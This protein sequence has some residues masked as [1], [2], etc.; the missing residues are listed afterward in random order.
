MPFTAAQITTGATYT[1]NT[2]QRTEPLDQVNNKHVLL[3]WLLKN[4]QPVTFGNGSHRVPLY[5]ANT[6]NY[7]NYFG[8]DQ[9]TYNER[10]PA[11]WAEYNHYNFHDGFWFDEDRLAAN[12]IIITDDANAVPTMTEK[13]Q[14]ID[15]LKISYR[16]LKEGVQDQLS[17]ELYRDGTQSNKACPGA[18]LLV[19][20]NPDTGTVAGI[21]QA[22]STW[23][24]NNA[25]LA[26][27]AD[28]N[29]VAGTQQMEVMWRA[30]MRYGG[31][32][33]D[34]IVCGSGFLDA[35]RRN[36][37][38]A[39]LRQVNDGG[40]RKGGASIDASVSDVYWHGI[41][42][43]WDPTLDGLDT[44]LSTTT[45]AKTC[46][47]LNSKHIQLAPMKGHWM[48]NRKPERLPDR[49]V[50]YFGLT[51]KYSLI[52]NRRNSLAVLQIA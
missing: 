5:T 34:K 30:C 44:L 50:H 10:D 43:E 12:G 45:R 2:Y 27:A 8:A 18:E 39:I 17:F 6:T 40:A 42:V 37:T 24:R 25:S 51:S 28:T 46:Y 41:P 36:S 16:S 31:A 49:Y 32:L 13:E 4:K 9:V 1:L 47:F 52:A 15:L 14:L 20:G 33:P 23:W 11:R 35:L 29:L 3:D 19:A 48:V 22:T 26:I 7:Q 38:T 21:N